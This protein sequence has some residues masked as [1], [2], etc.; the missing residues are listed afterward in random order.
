MRFEF[1][2]LEPL[3][4]AHFG[5]TRNDGWGDFPNW[6]DA[7]VAELLGVNRHT[8]NVW[9]REGIPGPGIRGAQDRAELAA[10]ALG[11]EPW[12]IWPAWAA[13]MDRLADNAD[14]AYQKKLA[15]NRARKRLR[16]AEAA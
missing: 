11:W 3:L 16:K 4:A 6:S 8:V 7:D 12:Q 13:E 14:S 15:A 10:M 9:K 5:S 2:A 1:A